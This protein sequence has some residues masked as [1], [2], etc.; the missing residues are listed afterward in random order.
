MLS[1]FSVQWNEQLSIF[2]YQS[3]V[4]LHYCVSFMCI[5]NWFIYIHLLM[6]HLGCFH[7]LAIKN[8]AAMNIGVHVSSWIRA[9]MFPDKSPGLGLLDH[10]A[11]LFLVF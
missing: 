10:M 7:V 8:G 5:V 1:V 4:D 6:E 9:F 2:F 11:T 3:I